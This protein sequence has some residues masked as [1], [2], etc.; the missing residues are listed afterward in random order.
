[1]K[2]YTASKWDERETISK[3]NRELDSRHHEIM[4]DWTSHPKHAHNREYA[5][6]AISGIKYCDLLIA[7]MK[8]DWNYKGAWVEIGAALS[9][10]IEVYVIGDKGDSI[11]FMHHPLVTKFISIEEV[12]SFLDT[13]EL[14]KKLEYDVIRYEELKTVAI[15]YDKKARKKTAT[16]GKKILKTEFQLRT[17]G[18]E[19]CIESDKVSYVKIG[20]RKEQNTLI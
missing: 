2:I 11:V 5:I 15:E 10:N 3:I 19:A 1:M 9:L 14:R 4:A 12:M 17:M 16:L 20:N 7:Y 18:W 8:N 6:G 13:Y